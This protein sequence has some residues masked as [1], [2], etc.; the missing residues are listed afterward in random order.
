[1]VWAWL[2]LDGKGRMD[3]NASITSKGVFFLGGWAKGPAL[4]QQARSAYTVA[5]CGVRTMVLVCCCAG[6]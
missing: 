3:V 2:F 1:M 5:V 4:Q 6:I